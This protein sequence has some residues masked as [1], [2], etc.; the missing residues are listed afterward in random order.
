M[1]D[2]FENDLEKIESSKSTLFIKGREREIKYGFSAWAKLD[3]KYNGILKNIDQ[4][5]KDFEDD[6]FTTYPYI[7]YLGLQDKEGVTEE[8]V[9]DEFGINDLETIS[10][11][12][13]K[14]LWGSLPQG[15]DTEKKTVI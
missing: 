11:V 15:T 5:Q 8:N 4:L 9:L 2:L 13:L 3:R 10:T 12:I 7:I 6:P 1:A 14:A